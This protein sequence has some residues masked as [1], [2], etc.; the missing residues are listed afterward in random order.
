MLASRGL[1]SPFE[2]RGDPVDGKAAG[3]DPAVNARG[4]NGGARRGGTMEGGYN[5]RNE[6]NF[7]GRL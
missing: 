6:A 7:P 5:L 4:Y 3:S 1:G 2:G